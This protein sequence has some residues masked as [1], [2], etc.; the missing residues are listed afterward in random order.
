MSYLLFLD[1]FYFATHCSSQH[2][3]GA[4]AT[5][6]AAISNWLVSPMVLVFLCF[7]YESFA[8]SI[9]WRK[10]GSVCREVGFS[11]KY[12]FRIISIGNID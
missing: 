10:Y 12:L 8:G 2:V 11:R 1:I 9:D 6:T 7:V 5:T 3:D 4:F